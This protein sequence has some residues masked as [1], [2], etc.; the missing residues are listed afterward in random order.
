[1]LALIEVQANL[2]AQVEALENLLQR[3]VALALESEWFGPY[4]DSG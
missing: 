4:E 2:L 1:L 3:V